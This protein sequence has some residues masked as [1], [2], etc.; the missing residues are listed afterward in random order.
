M[1]GRLQ[2][3]SWLLLSFAERNGTLPEAAYRLLCLRGTFGGVAGIIKT[4]LPEIALL[5]FANNCLRKTA[6]Y[7]KNRTKLPLQLRAKWDII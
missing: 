3:L 4:S 6:T 2:Q 7:V 5:K 1:R